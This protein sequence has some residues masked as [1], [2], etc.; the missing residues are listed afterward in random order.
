MTHGLGKECRTIGRQKAGLFLLPERR[1][2]SSEPPSTPKEAGGRKI[3]K[4]VELSQNLLTKD[5]SK[6]INLILIK[7]RVR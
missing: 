6:Q 4:N 7:S 1:E 3:D 2:A 5:G